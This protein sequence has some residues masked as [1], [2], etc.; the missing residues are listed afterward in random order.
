MKINIPAE[1][2]ASGEEDQYIL[3]FRRGYI[4]TRDR[5]KTSRDPDQAQIWLEEVTFR[6]MWPGAYDAGCVQAIKDAYL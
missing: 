2:V 4:W 1:V 3:Y 6:E 5:D